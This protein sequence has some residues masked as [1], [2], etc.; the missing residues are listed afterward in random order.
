MNRTSFQ[1]DSAYSRRPICRTERLHLLVN[2]TIAIRL[3]PIRWHNFILC[4][5]F[6]WRAVRLQQICITSLCQWAGSLHYVHTWCMQRERDECRGNRCRARARETRHFAMIRRFA[7]F[8]LC[9]MIAGCN[10]IAVGIFML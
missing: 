1:H 9:V 4:H 2:A 6:V 5:H 3:R 10:D 7:R 8:P